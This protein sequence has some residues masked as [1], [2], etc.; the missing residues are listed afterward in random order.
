MYTLPKDVEKHAS[1]DPGS[2]RY[3]LPHSEQWYHDKDGVIKRERKGR[4]GV[5]VG[6]AF[7]FNHREATAQ[8]R[9]IIR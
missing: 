2:P 1:L 6:L 3:A 5:P 7:F 4:S 9:L 8:D